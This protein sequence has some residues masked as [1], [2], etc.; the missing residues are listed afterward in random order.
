MKKEKN[1]LIAACLS[2]LIGGLGQ[3][4]NGQFLKGILFLIFEFVTYKFG[5]DVG[6]QL[7][8]VPNFLV[9]VVA[10]LDA[11]LSAKP[12][13]RKIPKPKQEKKSPRVK[14]Y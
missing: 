4:Y 3:L 9:S 1:S 7:A 5:V 6:T 14:I 10:A 8:Y 13:N 2:L 11:Y 12:T